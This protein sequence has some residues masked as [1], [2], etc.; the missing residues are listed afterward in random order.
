MRRHHRP[1]PELIAF[2]DEL[3]ARLGRVENADA[4]RARLAAQ[5]TDARAHWDEA[6]R[7]LT[8]GRRAA[9]KRLEPALLGELGALGLAQAKV[10]VA[11][12]ALDQPTAAGAE[13]I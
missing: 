10:T 7:A 3:A 4:E 12:E 9:A 6:A 13:K 5:E 11:L 1:L 2:R 8:R